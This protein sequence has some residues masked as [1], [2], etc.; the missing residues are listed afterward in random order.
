MKE[1]RN[2]TLLEATDRLQ[3][4]FIDDIEDYD[5]VQIRYSSSVRKSAGVV[6]VMPLK[7]RVRWL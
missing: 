6:P 3:R 5:E 7:M 1:H 4:N 2:L